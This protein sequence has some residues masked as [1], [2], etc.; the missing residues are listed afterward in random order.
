MGKELRVNCVL[1]IFAIG[2]FVFLTYLV[3]AAIDNV[4][5]PSQITGNSSTLYD[6]GVFSVNWTHD[7]STGDGVANYTI[8]IYAD[9]VLYNYTATN[10]S[11]LGYSFNNRT[12]ANYTFFISATNVTPVNYTAGGGTINA[13]LNISM[14]VDTTSPIVILPQYTNTTSKANTSTLTLNV[15]VSDAL[16]GTTGSVCLV[17]VNGTNQTIAFSGGW[18]NSTSVAL[19]GLADGNASIILYV[20]DTVSN[21]GFNDSYIVQIDTT[22]P[23]AS[24]SC[25][26]S[27]VLTDSTVTCS[28]SGTDALSG[29]ASSTAT[30]TPST[31]QTGTFSYGCTV[32]DNAGNSATDIASYTVEQSGTGPSSSGSGTTT[33]F[34]TRGTFTVSSQEFIEGYNNKLLE[35]QRVKLSVNGET[36][37]VGVRDVTADSAN[38]EVT[39]T[40]QSKVLVVGEEWKVNLDSDDYYD[41]IVVLNSISNSQ[42]DVTVKSINEEI[43]SSVVEEEQGREGTPITGKATGEE[44][45]EIYSAG[46]GKGLWWLWA[47]IT[48]VLMAVVGYFLMK[49]NIKKKKLELFGNI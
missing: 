28:C 38:I 3:V 48:L 18:C 23:S 14:Y 35:K 1:L 9:G 27:T 16:S 37:Y 11:E 41:L 8:Y 10:N 4:P 40:P 19:T 30:A 45:E 5:I 34:W 39:S 26:P 44:K 24:A 47:I 13:T 15:S 6:E 29:I 33:S 22:T 17:D 31:A 46:D 42:A 32:T 21:L 2:I 7:V 25:S 36:H 20:N 12:E 49:K 43:P